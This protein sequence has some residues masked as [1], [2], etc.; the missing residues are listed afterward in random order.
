ML[1][2]Q[3]VVLTQIAQNALEVLDELLRRQFLV[4]ALATTRLRLNTVM[5]YVL[6]YRLIQGNPNSCRTFDDVEE[7]AE[8]DREQPYHHDHLM[9]EGEEPVKPSSPP[10]G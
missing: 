2:T 6:V 4:A 9:C 7:F 1:T 8:R 3:V 5:I 10:G